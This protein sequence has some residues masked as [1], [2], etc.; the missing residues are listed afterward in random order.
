MEL[1][2]NELSV[3]HLATN[4]PDA[5]NKILVFLKTVRA[6]KSHGFR[7]VRTHDD[8]YA[9]DL[10]CGYTASDFLTDSSNDLTLRTLLQS[11]VKNPFIPD[12]ESYEAEVFLL[13]KFETENECGE[14]VIPEGLAA[15]YVFESHSISFCGHS[16]WE[17]ECIPVIMTNAQNE[18]FPKDILNHVFDSCTEN[19]IFQN[20]LH[21]LQ[22]TIPLDS[23]TNIQLV[24]PPHRFEFD[25][26][27]IDDLISWFYDD[28]RFQKRIKKLIDDIELHPFSGGLGHTETLAGTGGKASKRIVGRDRIVYTYTNEKTIIHQCRGHYE[29][30]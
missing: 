7:Y 17:R 27:A 24:F 19:Q 3:P 16:H 21:S 11:I 23:L 22:T 25:P 10:G 9:D 28:I 29:D 5:K 12:V 1:F 2:F 15:T 4:V 18:T 30:H 14:M 20:W 6:L 8:F 26:Q 13:N